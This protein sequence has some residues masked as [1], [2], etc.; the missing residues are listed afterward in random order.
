M[1]IAADSS[2][3]KREAGTSEDTREGNRVDAAVPAICRRSTL[4]VLVIPCTL[5][6]L[7]LVAFTLCSSDLPR[8]PDLAIPQKPS[9]DD[10]AILLIDINAAPERQWAL[11]PRVGP[12]L[13]KR[14]VEER[15]QNGP[16]ES[17]EDLT[18]VHGI[19]E[20]TLEGIR[21]YCTVS[22]P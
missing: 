22:V 12:V 8:E 3:S 14:I 4:G 13:A 9:G 7:G 19:G 17:L 10:A 18:R 2:K 20:K 6:V 15:Q 1:V 5:V 11:M 21:P 16:F